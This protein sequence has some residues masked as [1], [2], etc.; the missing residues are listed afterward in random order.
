[1]Q[2]ERATVSIVV[3]CRNEAGA[4][5][6]L[7]RSISEQRMEGW[8][9][10]V[11]VADGRSEDGTRE[12]VE[13]YCACHSRFHMVDNEGLMV[14]TGLNRAIRMARGEYILRMD[15]RT[16]YDPTYGRTCL[17]ELTR[18]EAD[19]AG[20]P[21]RA[22]AHTRFGRAV[23][24]AY[25]SRF[26]TGGA[27]FHDLDYEG[28][29]ETVPYGCWR[30]STLEGLGLFDEALFRNQDDELNLRLVRA[31]GRI[32]QSPHIVSWYHPRETLRGLCA[33]F[34]QYGF[35][36]VAVM[37][38]HRMAASWRHLVAPLFVLVMVC[39]IL[40]A[41]VAAWLGQRELLLLAAGGLA[42]QWLAYLVAL[43]AAAVMTAS[44]SGWEHLPLLPVVFAAYHLSWGTGFLLGCWWLL[45]RPARL[46]YK[47]SK[48]TEVNH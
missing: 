39:A 38:K 16:E 2:P 41:G 31:G 17:E 37:R 28:W 4:I 18:H 40:A 9:W 6:D 25:H 5:G 3:A 46:N 35:W 32:W 15:A 19:N 26:S 42:L 7:L 1:M 43:V 21:A 20:G 24:A 23:A 27:C 34:F 10:D 22:V 14:S 45:G 44:R 13:E 11:I 36:K 48:F 47:T 29:A 33:Q 12:I 8:E 30:K